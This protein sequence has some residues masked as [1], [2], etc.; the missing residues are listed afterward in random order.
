MNRKIMMVDD[1]PE[2]L[3]TMSKFF[4]R[5]DIDFEMAGN[6]LEA[7][8]LQAKG[9]F[10]VVIMDVSMPG[11]SGLECMTEMKT[12]QPDLK[13]IVLTGHASVS[14]GLIG[15]KQ[16][17]FDYCLKPVAFEELFEKILLARQ[18]HN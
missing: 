15:M 8:D 9:C 2:F 5:R 6:C 11:M 17:A 18:G 4:I 7:L 3:E 12:V 1:E 10:D 14:S 16:G 13:V